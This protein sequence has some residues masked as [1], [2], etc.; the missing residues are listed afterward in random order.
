MARRSTRVAKPVGRPRPSGRSRFSLQATGDRSRAVCCHPTGF[1]IPSLSVTPDG[2]QLSFLQSKYQEDVW[3]A[4][5][6]ANNL[7]LVDPR[8]LTLEDLNDRPTA[9][10]MDS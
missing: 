2:K 6:E 7:R 8:R 3:V 9:W 10:T 4:G 1:A 5:L